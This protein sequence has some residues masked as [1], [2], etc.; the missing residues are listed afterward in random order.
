MKIK[1][2]FCSLSNVSI[3]LIMLLF[4]ADGIRSQNEIEELE[5]NF[6]TKNKNKI[7]DNYEAKDNRKLI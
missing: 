6:L 3:I 7:N 4:L 5:N 2:I 1:N